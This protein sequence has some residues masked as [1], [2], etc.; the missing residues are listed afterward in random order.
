MDNRDMFGKLSQADEEIQKLN[1]TIRSLVD[2][3][4]NHLSEIRMLEENVTSLTF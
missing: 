3:E 1:F 2:K 4:Q